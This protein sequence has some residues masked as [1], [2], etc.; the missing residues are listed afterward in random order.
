MALAVTE[1][2]E[3]IGTTE[4]S[5][6]SD[7]AGIDAETTDRIV[8]VVVSFHNMAV[9]DVYK[10]AVYETLNAA[11]RRVDQWFFANVQASPAFIVPPMLL[12]IGYDVTC[13]KVAGTDRA[14]FW[15]LG[16]VT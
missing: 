1:L 13:T 10:I 2:S 16:Y 7:T 9:G 3:T 11:A 12:G 5:L 6:L 8:Q 14:I 4:W 15:T